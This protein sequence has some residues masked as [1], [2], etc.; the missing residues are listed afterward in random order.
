MGV[1][2]SLC[3]LEFT[4]NTV[5]L[6]VEGMTCGHCVASV[7]K[8]L[9]AVPG[10]QITAVTLGA[11]VLD[12]PDSNPVEVAKAAIA[13]VTAAGYPA[14]LSANLPGNTAASSNASCCAP[15]THIHPISRGRS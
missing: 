7:R 3:F 15:A 14:S 1:F 6:S 5:T 2:Y 13:A 10:A 11:A 9:A 4:M 8:A 12:V